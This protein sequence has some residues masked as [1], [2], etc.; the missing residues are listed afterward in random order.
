MNVPFLFN[1]DTR[2]LKMIAIA[3]DKKPLENKA[4][5]GGREGGRE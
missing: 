3:I 4:G 1:K 2:T 5:E